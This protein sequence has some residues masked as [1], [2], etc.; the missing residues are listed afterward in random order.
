MAV[1]KK[2]VPRP[3]DES[4]PD[5]YKRDYLE[6]Y[7]ILEDSPRMSA[8]LAR[9]IIADLLKDY[10]HFDNF[11]LKKQIDQFI[12]DPT[13]P[14]RLKDDLQYGRE[15]GDFGAHRMLDGNGDIVES[16]RED[17]QWALEMVQELFDYFIE[18]PNRSE[19]RRKEFDKKLK[20]ANRKPLQK[21]T[22]GKSKTE[23]TE[24]SRDPSSDEK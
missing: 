19:E 11:H 4:I 17:A 14:Q 12:A 8:V 23:D 10:G 15:I 9:K 2:R 20:Q 22:D 1:P 16:T 7:L 3:L 21:T 24:R 18:A 5:Q 6:A 13:H